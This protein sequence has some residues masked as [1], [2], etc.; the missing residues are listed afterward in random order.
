MFLIS[1][2]YGHSGTYRSDK[3]LASI[4]HDTTLKSGEEIKMMVQLNKESFVY[5]RAL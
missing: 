2:F 4:T 1:T 5:V 3:N